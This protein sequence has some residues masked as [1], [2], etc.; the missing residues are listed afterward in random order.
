L[1]SISVIAKKLAGS[2][3]KIKRTQEFLK[4]EEQLNNYF[5]TT[6]NGTWMLC[7]IISYYFEHGYT[8]NFNDLSSFFDTNIMSVIVYKDDI[9][10][11]LDKGY[12]SN[13]KGLDEKEVGLKNEFELSTE[14][15]HC[16]LHN[17]K[18]TLSPKKEKEDGLT[19]LIKRIGEMIESNERE[20][21][22]IRWITRIE[23]K[24]RNSDFFSKACQLIP[25]SYDRLFFY[26]TC[27]DLL[28]GNETN[29]CSTLS[30]IYDS[31]EDRFIAAES[32]LNEE[33]ALFTN[34]L[35]DFINKGNINDS[36]IE[37]TPKAK[38]MLLGE[39]A[40]LFMKSTKGTNLIN[41]EAIKQKS[42]FY[43]AENE[44]EIHRLKT[45]LQEEN[46]CPI[47][48]RLSE[49]GL[50]KGIAVLLYGAPGTG[51]TETVYQIAKE[52]G[53]QILH[54]DISSAKSCWF[55]ESEKITK[56]IFT[57]YK[58][59]CKAAKS[60]KDG[61]MPI[62]L[63]N[64]ADGILSKRRD[65]DL[66]NTTQTENTIQ[67]IILEEMETLEGI[68]ICTTNLSENLDT[69]FE[70][71]FLFKIMFEN[72]TIKAKEKIWK[73]KLDW[74]NDETISKVAQTYDLSGGQIDNIVRKITMDEV[75][76]GNKPDFEELN[77]LCKSE[78]INNT[79]RRIG[80]C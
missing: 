53:R 36:V 8:C 59:L 13:T 29:L 9:K 5:E 3:L 12:I 26:D 52:T 72:P 25:D 43:S 65:A 24:Y 71:R 40:K 67:N 39:K 51:K 49:K 31:E 64:E 77:A 42:L 37:L 61:K 56:K 70:R 78:K 2:N 21:L 62:L 23:K 79:E 4:A 10:V 20:I 80:F 32:F 28:N 46:L 76:T 75:L 68:M 17:K 38:E 47:Q 1:D 63:F 41:P 11:L 18:I 34:G 19:S 30:N 45:A 44:T 55:G 74:L 15:L 6:S 54:V 50:P 66:G 58:Q 16:I 22:K 60:E 7:G 33:N 14:L 35:I 48:E 73:S 27:S 57:D 69:A